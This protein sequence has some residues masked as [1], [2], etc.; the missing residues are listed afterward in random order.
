MD[1]L[2]LVE[3]IEDQAARL[4]PEGRDLA[5]RIELLAEAPPSGQAATY[6]ETQRA[7]ADEA[8]DLP[9]LDR[10]ILERLLMLWEGLERSDGAERRGEP[11]G[12]YLEMAVTGA[13]GLK[14]RYEARMIDPEMTPEQALARLREPE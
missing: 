12:R 6:E 3:L 9:P 5:E 2:A 14:D 8:W 7:Q 13:A 11:G 4:T 10:N 1:R